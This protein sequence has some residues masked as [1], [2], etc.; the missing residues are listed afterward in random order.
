[1]EKEVLN[2]I[3]KQEHPHLVDLIAFYSW[4]GEVNFIFPFV[5]YNLHTVLHSEWRPE[6]FAAQPGQFP[7]HW[8]WQQMLNVADALRAIHNPEVQSYPDRGRIIGFHFDLKPANIL[9][10]PEGVLQITDFGQSMI[11]LIEDDDENYGE[12]VGGDPGYQPP[13]ACPSREEVI[14]T[15][16]PHEYENLPQ[17][18]SPTSSHALPVPSTPGSRRSSS[19]VSNR[20]LSAP[21]VSES[22]AISNAPSSMTSESSTVMATS[23]YDVFSLACI[24]LEVLVYIFNDGSDGVLDFEDERRQAKR[25]LCFHD[26]KHLHQCVIDMMSNLHGQDIPVSLRQAQMMQRRS[27]LDDTLDFLA[28]MFDSD[29]KQR[30]SS[31]KVVAEF[32]RIGQKHKRINDPEL[33]LIQYLLNDP[34]Q[35]DGYNEILFSFED[36]EEPFYRMYAS[37]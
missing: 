15:V 35:G 29:P 25:G 32:E 13:E 26:G 5:E 6:R 22:S 27:Y 9:V 1:M 2:E 21:S 12:Y 10:T 20:H 11:K 30:P 37:L 31:A 23:N 36:G 4:R 17:P 16:L 34:I 3:S 33:E 24:M 28:K 7:H 8:L 14:R 18:L 19:A